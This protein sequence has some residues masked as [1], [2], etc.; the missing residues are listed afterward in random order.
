MLLVNTERLA[1]EA[2][3]AA[4]RPLEPIDYLRWAEEN[5]VFGPGEPRPGPYD[6]RAFGYFDEVLRSLG[7]DDPCRSRQPRGVGADWQDDF[8]QC[9]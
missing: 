5:I 3:A 1:H 2:V 8:G 4:F 7:P 9:L 6:R